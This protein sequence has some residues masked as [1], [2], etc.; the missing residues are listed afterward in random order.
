MS[1][2]RKEFDHDELSRFYRDWIRQFGSG[3]NPDGMRFGQ[4]IC[5]YFLVPGT[6]F[7]ELF[8]EEDAYEAYA[9]AYTEI[10]YQGFHTLPRC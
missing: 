7:P 1:R 8:N 2:F 10:N 9:L 4:Q 5:N 6:S 3:R